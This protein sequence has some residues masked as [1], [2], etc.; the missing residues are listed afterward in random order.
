MAKKMN[1]PRVVGTLVVILAIIAIIIGVTNQEGTTTNSDEIKI[2]AMFPL[3]GTLANLGSAMKDASQLAV[4]EV[5]LNGGINGKKFSLIVEDG[6]CSADDAVTA[7][8]KLIDIDGV[9]AIVGP[10]CSTETAA[11]GPIATSAQVVL[12]S[13]SATKPGLTLQAGDYVFRNVA[14]DSYQGAEGVKIAESLGTKKVAVLYANDEYG[15]ALK[16]V[17]VTEAQAK[18]IQVLLTEAM[19]KEGKDFRT[20]LTKIKNANPDLVY[21]VVFPK[22]GAIVLR[23]QKELG[24]TNKWIAA[25]AIKDDEVI[26]TTGDAGNGVIVTTP[27]V[28]YDN[29][30][31]TKFALDYKSKY[32]R[33]PDIYAGETYDATKILM[34]AAANTDGSGRAIREYL[35]NKE[36]YTLATGNYKFN[37]NREV[38]KDY[39]YWIIRNGKFE[40]YQV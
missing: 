4:D 25:E 9:K 17:F 29:E 22:E 6:K 18:G 11:L 10:T 13:P 2:G 1:W 36:S 34:E 39:Q 14:P 38:K 30:V 12:L 27:R 19:D 40:P 8:R 32:G 31:F 28:T 21:L 15:A 5:N 24:M 26:G 35:L 33:E 37:E 16:D 7:G 20:Q 3:S 23:Q